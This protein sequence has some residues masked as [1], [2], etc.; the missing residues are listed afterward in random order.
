MKN[1]HLVVIKDQMI[2]AHPVYNFLQTDVE[3]SNHLIPVR[4]FN[5]NVELC[6]VC[7]YR[8]GETMCLNYT[9]NS[10]CIQDKKETADYRSLG[11]LPTTMEMDLNR[12]LC[13][14]PEGRKPVQGHASHSESVIEHRK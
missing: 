14:F 6:V 13:S 2:G 7:V 3:P 12:C 11:A 9:L 5:G 1:F 4:R 10:C 8:R